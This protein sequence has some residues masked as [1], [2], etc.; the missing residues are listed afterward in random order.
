MLP[1]APLMNEH[2]LIERMI[3]LIED[4]IAKI[5]E[6]HKADTSFLVAVI[7]FFRIYAD[8]CHHG[9]EEEILFRELEGKQLSPELRKTMDELASEHALLREIVERLAR[10]KDDYVKRGQSGL[11]DIES[12]L[13]EIVELYPSHIIKEDQHFFLPV[14]EYF[15]QEEQNKMPDEFYEFDRK[16]IHEKYARIVEQFEEKS[17]GLY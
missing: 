2:R 3:T 10:A 6:L 8:R 15:T 17:E 1:V 16:M 4:E 7:D 13:S 11:K 9:K 14:M 5:S 12:L